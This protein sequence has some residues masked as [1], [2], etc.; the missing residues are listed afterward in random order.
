MASWRILLY[1]F[2]VLYDGVT[3]LRN[4]AFDA[5]VLKQTTFDIP[6]IAIGNLS[7]GGTGKTPMIEYC[8]EQL[9]GK[10]V[11]VL[12]RGYGRKT[13]GFLEVTNNSDASEVGD[14]PLQFKLKYGDDIIVA[15]CE[16]RADGI[17][18][19]ISSHDLDVI[20]LDDAYQHRY[21]KASQYI[22][23]TDYNAPYYKDH[24][25][26]AGNLRENRRGSRRA[27][28]I[29]VT[30]CPPDLSQREQQ[31]ILSQINPIKSQEVYFSSIQYDTELKSAIGVKQ[32]SSIANSNINL[33]TGIAKPQYLLEYLE[34]FTTVKHFKFKDH[35][36]YDTL[37]LQELDNSQI[38]ITTEKDYVKLR[39]LKMNNLFYL[40]IKTRFI[41]QPLRINISGS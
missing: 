27:D 20:L 30:K 15:V 38:T 36:E 4:S 16:K 32:L 22:M 19:L 24:V 11:A 14:E 6:V 34:Q 18:Q 35:H 31:H 28:H 26:P 12:S 9:A 33:I 7:T 39:K 41:G 10:K 8:I 13:K 17:E 25:L 5:G 1:P 40:P 29:V 37:D 21:V 23:L 3:G 2:S